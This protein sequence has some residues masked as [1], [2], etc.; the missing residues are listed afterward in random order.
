[1]T[2]IV[3]GLIL[4]SEIWVI[5]HSSNSGINILT[6]VFLGL[7]T[8]AAGIGLDFAARLKN[9]YID[10]RFIYLEGLRRKERIEIS[11]IKTVR[12]HRLIFRINRPITIVFENRTVF[13]SKVYIYPTITDK[14]RKINPLE[15]IDI[16]DH[17]MDAVVRGKGHR[18]N[19]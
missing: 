15:W 18:T 19:H 3:Y 6:L 11:N 2:P 1:M 16:K 12:S 14:N 17:L 4:S 9:A 10:E 13:G 8:T 7:V 5:N